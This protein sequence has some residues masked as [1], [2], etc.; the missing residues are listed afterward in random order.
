[1]FI[2]PFEELPPRMKTREVKRYLDSL[3]KKKADLL[4]KRCF[5]F[6]FCGL[7][8]LIALPFFLLFA[9]LV[10]L[11]S[12][13]P[14]FFKQERVGRDLK[15]FYIL[16][17]RTMTADADKQGV[18]LTTGNDSRITGF[19]A[20]LRKINMDEMPQLINVLKGDMSIIGTRPEVLRYVEVYT[21]EMLATLL[22]IP[23]MVSTASIHYKNENAMLTGAK[24]PQR[25][26]IDRILPDKMKYNLDY[27]KTIS[28]KN[29]FM[30]LGK[31][32]ACAFK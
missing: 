26:Y 31:T 13:G 6:I 25:V 22:L 5:D 1:M 10:K 14:V 3:E 11:T 29:D 27:L 21:D 28:I 2:T 19:G 8:F 12:R 23:G 15:P 16:K 18:Q 24:D 4:F 32:I 30:V 17:F 9:I 20:F 7:V